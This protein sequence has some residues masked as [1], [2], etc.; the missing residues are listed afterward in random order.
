MSYFITLYIPIQ[1]FLR[2]N[3][4]YF[5]SDCIKQTPVILCNSWWFAQGLPSSACDGDVK[6]HHLWAQSLPMGPLWLNIS[7]PRKTFKVKHFINKTTCIIYI[8]YFFY[9]SC[10]LWWLLQRTWLCTHIYIFLEL[11]A[12]TILIIV[13]LVRKFN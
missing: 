7:T 2:I 1:G 8:S 3:Q 6:S 9:L 10:L 4:R 12:S 13:S 5:I 11:V